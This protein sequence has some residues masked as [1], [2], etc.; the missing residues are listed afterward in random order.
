[1][2]KFLILFFVAISS[3]LIFFSLVYFFKPEQNINEF[4]ISESI[5]VKNHTTIK[6]ADTITMVLFQYV[7]EYDTVSIDIFPLSTWY[8]T[9][10]FTLKG[11][12]VKHP[13]NKNGYMIF[14]KQNLD[15]SEFIKTMCHEAIH[16]EQLKSGRL[17]VS[18]NRTFEWDGETYNYSDIPY[19]ERE[20]EI[21]AMDKSFPLMKKLK[22]LL[23]N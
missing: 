5:T 15:E 14:V 9:E 22:T 4:E 19:N 21:E 8:D 1:M 13:Y 18:N 11:M 10:D 3:V 16:V 2:K 7:M 6:L 12:T 20:Y 23:F 17:V